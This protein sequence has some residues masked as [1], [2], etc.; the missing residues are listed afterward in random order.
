MA[1]HSSILVWRIPWTEEP[2]WATVHEVTKSQ[3][4]S[5]GTHSH[6]LLE[7]RDPHFLIAALPTP[8][9]C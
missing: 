4:D 5:P 9:V 8:W 7:G 1:A 3:S 2:G 6:E